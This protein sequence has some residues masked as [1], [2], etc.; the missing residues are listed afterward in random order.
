VYKRQVLVKSIGSP[1]QI[2]VNKR[3][4]GKS[5]HPNIFINLSEVQCG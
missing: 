5:A 2:L 3:R 1:N 4:V